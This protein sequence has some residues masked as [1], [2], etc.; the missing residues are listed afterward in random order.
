MTHDDRCYLNDHTIDEYMGVVAKNIADYGQHIVGV[1][2]DGAAPHFTYTVGLLPVIGFELLVFGLPLPVAQPVLNDIGAHVR[3]GR[4]LDLD[5]AE[6]RFTN[7]PIKFLACG[8]K[9]QQYNGVAQRFYGR[10]VP[11][12]QVVIADRAGLFPTDAGFDHEYMD[13]M[14]PLLQ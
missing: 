9:A 1:F 11:M 14:Q 5:K 12:V 7:L 6:L 8:P 3:A 2:S 4:P 10:E 13:G